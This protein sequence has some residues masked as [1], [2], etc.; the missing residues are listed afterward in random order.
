MKNIPIKEIILEFGPLFMP[1]M[2]PYFQTDF[3]RS[4]VDMIRNKKD[5]AAFKKD[6]SGYA[7]YKTYDDTSH[8]IKRGILYGVGTGAIMGGGLLAASQDFRD[9]PEMAA[10]IATVPVI[11]GAL[12]GAINGIVRNNILKQP[13][14]YDKVKTK[15]N[16]II[17]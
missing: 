9:E 6:Y 4:K 13:T 3:A 10:G 15:E 12:G 7:D 1:A 5:L 16:S 8:N 2:I 17:R 11:T 14:L